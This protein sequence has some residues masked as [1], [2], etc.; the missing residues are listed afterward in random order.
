MSTNNTLYIHIGFPKT[1]TTTLQNNIFFGHNDVNYFGKP[2]GRV[3]KDSK[4]VDKQVEVVSKV[5]RQNN[6][7]YEWRR[8]KCLVK[9]SFIPFF[10]NKIKNTIS[11]EEFS[12]AS[13]RRLLVAGRLKDLFNK[14]R[15]IITIRS[16]PD[17]II[18]AY[19]WK[20][21]NLEINESFDNWFHKM[22]S[23]LPDKNLYLLNYTTMR[24]FNYAE[25]I[26]TYEGVFGKENIC[27]LPMEWLKFN[28][29]KYSY[30]LSSF[31]G[32][33]SGETSKLLS[34]QEQNTRMS[35][36]TIK[37]QRLIKR[38]IVSFASQ[39]LKN[40]KLSR[41]DTYQG[42][43]RKGPNGIVSDL[44]NR[45]SKKPTYNWSDEQISY[46]KSYYSH[47]NSLINQNYNLD[48]QK[49]GYLL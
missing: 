6:N 22:I 34:M 16:Q 7:E 2:F 12:Y 49:Y 30:S 32:I 5:W 9:E 48:L 4:L 29:D 10:D 47:G 11:L 46:L 40:E 14:C 18:S 15:I 33:K 26:D 41:T 23:I 39:F 1:A 19:F 20:H 35:Y 28:S 13:N 45:Y 25:V 17:A 44:L 3:V 38:L 24:L 37:Y 31:M 8:L 27:V 43:F 42:V 36:A 21:M